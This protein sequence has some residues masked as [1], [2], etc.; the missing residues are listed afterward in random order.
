MTNAQAP[1]TEIPAG[2]GHH[3]ELIGH[4]DLVIAAPHRSV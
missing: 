3:W 1:M 2:I 4:W